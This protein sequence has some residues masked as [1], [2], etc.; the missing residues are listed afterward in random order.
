[1]F[2]TLSHCLR[3]FRPRRSRAHCIDADTTRAIFSRP[4]LGQQIDSCLARAIKAH[5]WGPIIGNHRRYIDDCSFS[6]LRHQRSKFRDEE[7]RRL[8]VE[9]IHTV[10]QF[11]CHFVRRAE[12]K[13]SRTVDQN[14]DMALSEFEG[15]FRHLARRRGVSKVRRYEIRLGSSCADFPNCPL[16]AFR[17]AAY[18]YDMNADL[19]EFIGGRPPN[20]ARST[21]NKCCR[22]IGSHFISFFN[23]SKFRS[24]NTELLQVPDSF[25]KA[26]DESC[27]RHSLQS[28]E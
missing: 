22:R 4:G 6:S 13:D 12:R 9:R 14:I 20:T 17:I 11:F 19:G 7:V 23:V 27:N 26:Q 16:A 2:H 18:D 5:A 21:S 8:D 24:I 3:A 28:H 15:S 25:R 1:M 10:K